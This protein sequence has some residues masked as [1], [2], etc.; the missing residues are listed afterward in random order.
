[1][2]AALKRF[3]WRVLMTVVFLIGMPI[4][5]A[6]ALA[7][8]IAYASWAGWLEAVELVKETVPRV[9]DTTSTYVRALKLGRRLP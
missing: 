9:T 3:W 5:I 7:A 1:M 2:R 4:G 6:W 8:I